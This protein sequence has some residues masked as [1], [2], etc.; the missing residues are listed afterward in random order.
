MNMKC[1]GSPVQLRRVEHRHPTTSQLPDTA[2]PN[3]PISQPEQIATPTAPV[4]PNV[5]G[6][7]PLLP[8]IFPEEP[9]FNVPNNPLL[10]PEFQEVLSYSSI[11]YLNGFLRTQIGNYCEVTLLVGSN[12]TETRSGELLAVGINYILLLDTKSGD[13]LACDFYNIKFVRFTHQ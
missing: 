8:Q 1:A 9:M 4:A 6:T 5:P 7:S 11:Q 2:M 10:P 13:I 3:W 12:D